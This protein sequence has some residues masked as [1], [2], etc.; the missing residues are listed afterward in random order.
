LPGVCLPRIIANTWRIQ[1]NSLEE[2]IVIDGTLSNDNGD[3]LHEWCLAGLG[4]SLRE[5]CIAI[6]PGDM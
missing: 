5:T 3:V 2:A 4:I 6:L 1:K